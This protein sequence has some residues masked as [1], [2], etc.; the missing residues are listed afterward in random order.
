MLDISLGTSQ[1]FDI[2]QLKI[3]C[4]ALY[5]IFNSVDSLESNLSLTLYILD[6]STLADVELVKIFS[7]SVGCHFVLF[8]GSFA[9]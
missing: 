8:T 1:P 7:Q 2:P 4:V 3:C 5:P 6:I 9:L